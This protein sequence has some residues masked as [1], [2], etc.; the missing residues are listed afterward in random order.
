MLGSINGVNGATADTAVGIGTRMLN[1]PLGGN[2]PTKLNIVG[3]NTFVP[4]VVQNP[5]TFGT[6][7]ALNNTSSGGKDW[8]IS[9]CER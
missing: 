7:M 5:S 4:L 8:A 9:N 6:W 3:N 1:T 2:P